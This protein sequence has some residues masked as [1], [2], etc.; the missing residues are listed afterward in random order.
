[1]TGSAGGL[2]E[3]RALTKHFPM[4]SS[5]LQRIKPVMQ[6]LNGVSFSVNRGEAFCLVGE[7][8]CGKTT[9]GRTI[10]GLWKPTSGSVHYDGQRIDELD[11]RAML[12]FRRRMQMIFQNPYASLNPRMTVRQTLEEPLRFHRPEVH[13]ERLPHN[14]RGWP[15]WPK[16]GQLHWLGWTAARTGSDQTPHFPLDVG[17]GTRKS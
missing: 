4:P 12:A 9:L 10:M 3:I 1:M 11:D 13:R 15:I 14:Q 6:A 17:V 7:S 16:T 8:G 2:V 5:F